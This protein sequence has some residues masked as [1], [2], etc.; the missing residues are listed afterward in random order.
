MSKALHPIWEYGEPIN[1]HNWERVMCKLCVKAMNVEISHL[2][3][4]LATITGKEVEICP[5]S[6]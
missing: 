2:K 3:Y 1:P 4:D 6:T 5:T